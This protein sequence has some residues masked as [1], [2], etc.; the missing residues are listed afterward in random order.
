MLLRVMMTRL[1]CFS[2]QATAKIRFD[3]ADCIVKGKANEFVNNA[4]HPGAT[5]IPAC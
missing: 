5:V 3:I 2:V 4:W 1:C